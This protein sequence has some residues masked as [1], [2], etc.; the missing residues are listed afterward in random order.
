[1][2]KTQKKLHVK[3]S[4]IYMFIQIYVDFEYVK[5]FIDDK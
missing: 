2:K 3:E 5:C 1:M 4:G